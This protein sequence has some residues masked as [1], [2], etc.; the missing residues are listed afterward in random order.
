MDRMNESSILSVIAVV[1]SVGTT[2]IGIINHK[3]I[4][5]SCCG[6]KIEVSVDVEETTPPHKLEIKVPDQSSSNG[7]G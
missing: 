7:K 5:S 4:R 1:V 6:K 2:V 3:R